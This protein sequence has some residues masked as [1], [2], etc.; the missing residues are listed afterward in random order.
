MRYEKGRREASRQRIMD[1]ATERFRSDGIAA[2]GLAGIMGEAGLTNGA[3]YPHFPSKAALVRESVA[4]ALEAQTAQIQEL[5]A[6][7]GTSLAIDTYLSAEHRDNPGKGCA[8][9][10]LLPEIA[11]EPIETRQVYAEHL[12]KLVRQVAA[13]L[14]PDARDPEAVAFGVFATLIGTLELSRAVNGTELS[15]RILEAGAVAAK[16]L[17]QPSGSDS[18]KP[19]G[20]KP[21]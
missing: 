19:E 16:A 20:R 10:A 21:S 7:G 6:A 18:D 5:L 14:T 8:S 13:E 3:F 1:V 17:L 11:R 12:L 4:A 2:S 15:D 9:A